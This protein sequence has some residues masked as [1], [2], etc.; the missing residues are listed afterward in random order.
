MILGNQLFQV[1]FYVTD[2][3]VDMKN[4][5]ISKYF[6]YNNYS[7][8]YARYVT[9]GNAVKNKTN[10]PGNLVMLVL[11]LLE[12]EVMYGWQII[13]ELA[14]RSYDVF[15]LKT[16][17]LYPILHGM[18]KDGIISSCKEAIHNGRVRKYYRI[19][20]SGRQELA[21]KKT[22]W[23]SYAKAVNHVMERGGSY[24]IG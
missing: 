20:D 2:Q 6:T 14:L 19:T 13:E 16:G 24:A 22:E 17:A 21:K 9:G 18:E 23:E 11:K 10:I 7:I 1:N 3:A 5:D 8:M 15:Q 12:E 4:L